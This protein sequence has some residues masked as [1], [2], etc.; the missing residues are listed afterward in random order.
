MSDRVA[1][2]SSGHVE[3]IGTVD[4]IYYKPATRFVATFIG[5]TNIV[6]AGIIGREADLVR[7]RIEGGLELQVKADPTRS[8]DGLL[9]SL[10]P[11]K[12]RLSRTASSGLNVFSGRILS[13]VFKGAV[14]DLTVVVAGG[15]ELRAL[16]ANDGQQEFDFHEG[17]EVFCRIQPEDINVVSS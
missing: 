11:E 2:I 7:C 15:L 10:R 4:E 5:E 9:L 14:D 12:I 6:E 3:Q 1:V 8:S 13:E 17:E 16:I